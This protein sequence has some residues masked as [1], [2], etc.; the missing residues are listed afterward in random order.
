MPQDASIRPRTTIDRSCPCLVDRFDHPS[1]GARGRRSGCP[2][3]TERRGAATTQPTRAAGNNND[4]IEHGADYLARAA[5][6]VAYEPHGSSAWKKCR[7][8]VDRMGACGAVIRE[9]QGK[10]RL[11][12]VD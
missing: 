4:E 9:E 12:F 11:A 1:D 10:E 5:N 7:A 2:G 3:L 8:E 6:Y